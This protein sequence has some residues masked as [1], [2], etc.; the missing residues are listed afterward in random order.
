MRQLKREIHMK[1]QVRWIYI[2]NGIIIMMLLGTVYSYSIFRKSLEEMFR[3]GSAE[4]GLPYMVALG[5]YALFMF[6]SGKMIERFHPRR[7]M[8][9]GGFLVSLGW[10]LSYFASGVT[11]LVVT[12]GMIAGAGVGIAY[13]VIINVVAKWFVDKR[14]FAVGLVLIGFG[15]SPL[16][17]APIVR[18]LI[19]NFGIMNTFLTLGLAYA[20]LIPVLAI[21]FRYPKQN[22]TDG[23][24]KIQNVS[25]DLNSFTTSEMVK[26]KRFKG[27]YI[28]F[29]IGTMIGLMLIG[30][31]FGIGTDYVGMSPTTVTAM[32]SAFAI[33]NGMGRPFSGWLTERLSPLKSMLISYGLIMIAS[34]I[35]IISQGRM[36]VLY[37]V[38][39]AM[40]W[41]NLGSWLAIAPTTTILFFGA[42][43][44]SQNYSVVFTAYGIGAI[45]GVLTSGV[46][47]DIVRN[48]SILF[49]YIFLLGLIGV[50][51][52]STM[53][54]DHSR[55]TV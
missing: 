39:F 30:L 33:F 22:E 55:N 32:I 47:I 40:F 50:F 1:E 2:F 21:P 31:T 36:P 6:L 18:S 49:Y 13:G 26:S 37:F 48:Y 35:M 7:M 12:Y 52:C 17:V 51:V 53:L 14:G 15:M 45:L 42:K 25:G 4:S 9:F 16:I 54:K 8:L 41:F 38:A 46:F 27:L 44:Y 20:V 23:F 24:D 11:H 3:I 34:V 43:N 5:F 28:N 29:I 19:S 10:I